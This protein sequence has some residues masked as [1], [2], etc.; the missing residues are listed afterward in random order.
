[1]SKRKATSRSL[2]L[3]SLGRDSYAS[4]SASAKLLAYVREHGLP[5]T[6]D[7]SAQFRA[8]KDVCRGTH[9]DYGPHIIDQEVPLVDGGT[10]TLPF[11]NPLAFF[12][13]HCKH[14]PHYSRIV[15]NAWERHAATAANPWRIII[16]QDGVDPSD[17][18]SKNHSRK[19]CVFYWSFA[20]FGLHALGHEQ[21]W[22]ILCTVRNS[23]H[24]RLAGGI[25]TLFQFVLQQFFGDVHDIRRSGV[26]VDLP[27]GRSVMVIARAAILLADMPAIKECIGCKGHSGTVCCCLCINCTQHNSPHEESIP[28]HLLAGAAASIAEF[29]L[30]KFQK[31]NKQSVQRVI[32]KINSYYAEWRDPDN[33]YMTKDRFARLCIVHGWNYTL[34]NVL[35]NRR[36]DL[37]IPKMVMFD[38]AHL[39]VHDGLGD[40]ELGMMMKQF[41]S[42]RSSS[43][44]SYRELKDY[45]KKFTLPKSAPD[46]MCLFTDSAIT[47]NNKNGKFSC[48]GSQCIT[49]VPI[50]HRY[51]KLVVLP[52]GEHVAHVKSMLAV[53]DVIMLL[54]SLKTGTVSA[55]ELGEAIMNH[56][57]QFKAVYGDN[58]VRPKHHYSTHLPDMLDLFGFL[59]ATFTHERKHR[60]ITRY[61]RDRKNLSNWDCSAIEEITCHQI[62]EL[63]Q[64]FMAASSVGIPRGLMLIPLREMFPGVPDA[65]FKTLSGL[66]CNG[67]S[68]SPG[69]VI[70]FFFEN[71]IQLGQLL[72]MVAVGD[73][74]HSL[75]ARWTPIG[76]LQAKSHWATYKV[77]DND[78]QKVPTSCIDT[79]FIWMLSEDR[80]QCL[81]YLPAEIRPRLKKIHVCH[82][83]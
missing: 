30:S 1:M 22:G 73:Q 44:C 42:S 2:E 37:D 74:A 51:L 29:D 77:V 11:Q 64:P 36:F 62:W 48:S 57:I 14:S 63:A 17:M 79:V 69:D 56:L 33:K 6:F 58:K 13:Y 78:V 80:K 71:R 16:Y 24:Q 7:R 60:L 41:T 67:G 39:Y 46:I 20:E 53:L 35:L 43:A 12:N 38:W 25:T 19:C 81:V 10:T 65:E 45:V 8:R 28:V 34:A 54:M 3:I 66:K 47:N 4:H 72:M 76:Q 31:H 52:R 27:H 50:L 68:C 40:V 5:E 75:I 55:G 23:E 32:E 18:G 15:A 82:S 70:S 49:L 61:C 26:C 83:I 21:V 9:T 59:L